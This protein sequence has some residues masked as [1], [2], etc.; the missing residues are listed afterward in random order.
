MPAR[1][2]PVKNLNN[3]RLTKV[4]K[5]KTAAKLA[6]AASKALLKNTREGLYRSA[7][8]SIAYTNVPSMNPACTAEVR[9]IRL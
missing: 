4:L 2:K 9:Y 1:K 5:S 8:P 7:I 3:P 6:K